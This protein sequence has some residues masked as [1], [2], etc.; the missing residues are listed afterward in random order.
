[1]N[2]ALR[3]KFAAEEPQSLQAFLLTSTVLLMLTEG[4]VSPVHTMKVYDG[5]D[6]KLHSF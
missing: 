2:V 6:V 3:E 5:V 1:M 4:N